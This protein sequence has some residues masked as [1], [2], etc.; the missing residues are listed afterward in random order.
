MSSLGKPLESLFSSLG[1][2][3]LTTHMS[4]C[5]SNGFLFFPASLAYTSPGI[6]D[7]H[8]VVMPFSKS[9]LIFTKS[10]WNEE[11]LFEK[12]QERVLPQIERLAKRTPI[13]PF[14]FRWM[15]RFAKKRSLRHGQRTSFKDVIV[16]T[17]IKII[18][19]SGGIRS[20]G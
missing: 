5:T 1:T 4:P 18:K 15:I 14:S 20:F 2:Q 16:M 13:S 10:P 9:K 12:L 17:P 11:R 7:R 3:S 6:H 8:S 19:W